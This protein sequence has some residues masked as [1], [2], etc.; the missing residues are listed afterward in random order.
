M[1]IRRLKIYQQLLIVLFVAVFL[2]LCITTLIVTNV[3][4]HAV[5]AELRYSA[6][7]TTDSVYQ[8]LEKSIHEKKLAILFIA[9]SV[10]YIKSEEIVKKFLKEISEASGSIT[11]IDL[12][13]GDENIN[14]DNVDNYFQ[15]TEVEIFPKHEQNAILMYVKL[16]N[17]K[18]LRKQINIQTIQEELFKYI[19]NDKRQ[20]YVIDSSNKIIMAYNRD[21]TL[22]KKLASQFPLYSKVEEPIIFGKVKNLPNV[23]LKIREP[24]W[25]IVVA[26]PESLISYGII[27]ARFKIIT[28]I[29]VAATTIIVLGMLY[30][31]SLN[32]NLR[33]LFK[34]VS[35]IATGNYRRKARLVKDFFTPYEFAY[36]IEKI[37]EMAQKIDESHNALQ[38]ANEELSKL[39]KLKSTLIDTVSHEFRTPLTSIKGYTSRLLRNDVNIDEETKT[40]SLKVIKRQT[41]RLSRLV[42]DLLV[43]PEIESSLLRIFPENINLNDILEDCSLLIQQKQER[44]INIKIEKNFPNIYADSD[45]LVQVILNLLDNSIKY[46]SVIRSK[47]PP[48]RIHNFLDSERI[49]WFCV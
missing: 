16:Q 7:I 20:V 17:G 35:A 13:E 4:Q 23:Y 27:S 5:R 32:T 31:Y 44:Q 2:P 26:T 28:A 47:I 46:S 34:A 22:F 36:L 43:I 1:R 19:V 38:K 49:F 48:E 37:N 39:D 18:F 8:R 10:D 29:V 14:K 15:N 12:I 30:S 25:S 33:Q 41:G 40:K 6:I 3:N 21:N 9:K 11:S 24:K 45:R 42:E